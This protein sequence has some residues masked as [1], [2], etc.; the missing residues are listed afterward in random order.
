MVIDRGNIQID[1]Y[2][3]ESDYED[4]DDKLYSGLSI[5]GWLEELF[6]EEHSNNW[7]HAIK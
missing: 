2:F 7:I 5:S 1:K 6:F 3:F 4:I